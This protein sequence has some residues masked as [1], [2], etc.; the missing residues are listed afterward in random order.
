MERASK[1]LFLWITEKFSDSDKFLILAG[2]GNNGG[3]ALALSR[4]LFRSGYVNIR[5]CLLQISENTTKDYNINLKRLNDIGDIEIIKLKSNN[6]FPKICNNTIVIDGIFGSG[7]SKP[8]TGYWA[9]LINHINKY[10]NNTISID[11]P[12]GVYCDGNIG[13]T[14]AKIKATVTLTFQF[15]KMSSLFADNQEY[16]GEWHTLDI[17]LHQDYFKKV[18]VNHFLLDAEDIKNIIKKRQTFDHKGTFGHA[19]LIAGSYCKNGAAILSA[20]GCLRSGVGLLTVHVPESGR[21]IIQTAVPEAMV[22]IDESEIGYNESNFLNNFAAVGI[23]PGIGT[24][25]S[26][27]NALLKLLKNYTGKIVIDADAIN[28]LSINKEWFKFLNKNI[29]LTP[30]PGEFDK[31]T[32]KHNSAY[33]RFITQCEFTKKHKAIVVLKGAYTSITSPDGN[34][35]FNSTGNP[36]MATGGSGDVLTGIILSMLAQGYTPVGASKVGVFLHGLSGDI[37]AYKIG[38]E[39]LIASDIVNNL[40]KAFKNIVK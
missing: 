3:D 39:A 19:L 22:H 34:V 24:K 9:D 30:H 4:L 6:H 31:L 16:F 1:Q 13:N 8:V 7:L 12:S 29:I 38:F 17:G 10:S 14:G 33:E 25:K 18:N 2:T 26:V 27:Q 36:G 40:G 35:F 21:E 32:H 20:K 37:A 23:G 28:I 11:I 5:V 15:P